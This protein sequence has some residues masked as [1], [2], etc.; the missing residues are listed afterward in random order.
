MIKNVLMYDYEGQQV[1]EQLKDIHMFGSGSSGNSLYIKP[2]KVI[3]DMGLPYKN[4]DPSIFYDLKYVLLT[5]EHGDHFY[6]TTIDK[7]SKTFP[8]ITFVMSEPLYEKGIELFKKHNRNIEDINYQILSDEP[9]I[10]ETQD[11]TYAMIY[12]NVTD[13]G[14]ITNVAY[15]IKG[16][17]PIDHIKEPVILYASDLTTTEPYKKTDG[18]PKDE[19]YNLMFLEANYNAEDVYEVLKKDPY[20][21]KALGNLRHLSEINAFNYVRRYLAKDGLYIPLHA[22]GEFGSFIQS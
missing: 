5:H 21:R 3:I 16:F 7:I 10:Y 15:T 19:S 1:T 2:Y 18:L 4:Y 13:H 11:D 17:E 8:H 20:D 6:V 14:D 9:I 22:S 12:H